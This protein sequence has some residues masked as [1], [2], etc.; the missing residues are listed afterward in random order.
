[1]TAAVPEAASEAVPTAKRSVAA[2]RA[3][4]LLQLNMAELFPLVEVNHSIPICGGSWRKWLEILCN[5]VLKWS[6]VG[7]LSARAL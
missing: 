7:T 4:P 6:D 5:F 3:A 1:L 2:V